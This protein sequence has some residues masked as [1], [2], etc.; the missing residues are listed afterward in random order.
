MDP[1]EKNNKNVKGKLELKNHENSSKYDDEVSQGV[2]KTFSLRRAVI[3]IF[4]GFIALMLWFFV[5]ISPTIIFSSSIQEFIGVF[6]FFVRNPIIF[7]F[8]ALLNIILGV[9]VFVS[10]GIWLW[11]AFHF[12]WSIRWFYGY[13]KYRSTTL[14][15][16]IEGI[17]MKNSKS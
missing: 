11:A 5:G 2:K 8:V 12:I 4:L 13:F 15:D 6:S 7:L 1:N 14:R 9:I 16:V 3:R 10:F 17:N